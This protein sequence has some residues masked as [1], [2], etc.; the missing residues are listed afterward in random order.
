MQEGA[1]EPDR[2]PVVDEGARDAPQ[3][4]GHYSGDRVHSTLGHQNAGRRH[5]ELARQRQKRGLD[6]HEQRDSGVA[7][8]EDRVDQPGDH[9]FEHES[10]LPG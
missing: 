8:L 2:E 5:D 1:P 6:R 9:S 10:D 3:R 4:P 7:E